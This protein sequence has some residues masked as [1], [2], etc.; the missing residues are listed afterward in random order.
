M[1]P[2]QKPRTGFLTARLIWNSSNNLLCVFQGF[3]NNF[4]AAQAK[5]KEAS[6]AM[7]EITQDA[8]QNIQEKASRISLSVDLD[9]PYIIVPQNSKSYNVLVVDFGHLELGN[10]FELAGKSSANGIPAILNKIG[11]TLS[12]LKVSR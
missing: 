9:A 4:Q 5:L 6:D 3:L 10:K 12:D 1:G 7:A 8:V 2:G 11:L